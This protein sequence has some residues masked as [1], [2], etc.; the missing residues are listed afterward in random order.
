[1]T[2]GQLI[3]ML[4]EYDEDTPVSFA[5]QPGWAMEYS[6]RGE[7]G[8]DND[9]TVYLAEGHQVGYLSGDAKNSLGW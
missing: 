8:E 5:A 1:M 6:I 4:Q 9:G 3:E 2:T 7:L